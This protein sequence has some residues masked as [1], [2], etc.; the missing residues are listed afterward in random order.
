MFSAQRHEV[1]A[2]VIATGSFSD[3]M[4]GIGWPGVADGASLISDEF[5]Q[6]RIG[7]PLRFWKAEYLSHENVPCRTFLNC[8]SRF[9]LNELF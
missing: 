2:R 8:I 3:H 1:I 4:M 6:I 9:D 5:D 7:D